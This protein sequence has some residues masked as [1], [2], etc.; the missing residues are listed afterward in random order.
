[1][2]GMIT[3]GGGK[4]RGISYSRKIKIC[5]I[6]FFVAGSWKNAVTT[7]MKPADS[8][9][10]DFTTNEAID[11]D[12]SETAE[13]ALGKGAQPHKEDQQPPHKDAWLLH[14]SPIPIPTRIPRIVNKLYFQK[15]SGFPDAES[16]SANLTLAHAS[17]REMNPGYNIRYFDLRRARQYLSAHFHPVFL[18]AF[19]CLQA[20]AS[21]ADLFRMSVLFREGGWYSDWKEVCLKKNILDELSNATDFFA[22]RAGQTSNYFYSHECIQNAFVGTVP[23]HPIITKMVGISL[24]NIQQTHYGQIAFDAGSNVCVFGRAIYESENERNSTWFS[25]V[26][27]QPGSAGWTFHWNGHP[28]VLHKNVRDVEEGR[29]GV[30]RVTI[31]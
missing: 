23:Q 28:I 2:R 21:K 7:E 1:M 18:R 15:K 16:M 13:N 22:V 30:I 26:A 27:G 17:W 24:V 6:A 20:F 29:T 14:H 9:I 4:S 11:F 8:T 31:I 19:D 25:T 12:F 3:N 10:R 5:F